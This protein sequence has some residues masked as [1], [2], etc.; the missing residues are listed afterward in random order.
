MIEAATGLEKK[1][2]DVSSSPGPHL[3]SSRRSSLACD[4]RISGSEPPHITTESLRD[5]P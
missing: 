4:H 2:E 1:E 5:S 3:V